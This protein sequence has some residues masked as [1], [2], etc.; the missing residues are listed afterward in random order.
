MEEF[1]L[2]LGTRIKGHLSTGLLIFGL[3][4]TIMAKDPQLSLVAFICLVYSYLMSNDARIS[5]FEE[6]L[7]HSAKKAAAEKNEH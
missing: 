1:K 5:A 2:S 6:M 7:T 3:V 4:G